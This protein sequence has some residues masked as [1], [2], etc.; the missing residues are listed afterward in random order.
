MADLLVEEERPSSGSSAETGSQRSWVRQQPP[1]MM[2][3]SPTIQ[4]QQKKA[5]SPHPLLSPKMGPSPFPTAQTMTPS[6]VRRTGSIN[7]ALEPA[8]RWENGHGGII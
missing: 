7:G 8:K 4:Q 6:V 1:T 3:M 2:G 5:A